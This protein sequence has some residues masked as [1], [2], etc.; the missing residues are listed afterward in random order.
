MIFHKI[1]VFFLYFWSDRYSLDEQNK[2][3]LKTLQI[4]QI[5]NFWAAVYIY[6]FLNQTFFYVSER[7][8]S[9]L[10]DSKN[11][12]CYCQPAKTLSEY[13]RH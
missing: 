8:F 5:P 1:T 13:L 6:V 11:G 10:T 12:N 7:V 3:L 4:L 2:P 9:M